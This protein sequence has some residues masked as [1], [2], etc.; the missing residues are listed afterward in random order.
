MRDF[1]PTAAAKPNPLRISDGK[2]LRQAQTVRAGF[3]RVGDVFYQ[4]LH[5]MDAKPTDLARRNDAVRSG[6][7]T[8]RGSKGRP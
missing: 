1:T 7:G 5:E 2:I 6:V 3:S 4:G 8:P